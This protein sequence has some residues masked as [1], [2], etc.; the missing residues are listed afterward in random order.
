[1]PENK[2]LLSRGHCWPSEFPF[3][4]REFKPELPRIGSI[5][6]VF[7][8]QVVYF[9]VDKLRKCFHFGRHAVTST[10]HPHF[11]R[12]FE[13]MLLIQRIHQQ[14]NA[15]SFRF[16]YNF[17]SSGPVFHYFP[18]RGLRIIK[19]IVRMNVRDDV[20]SALLYGALL[21]CFKNI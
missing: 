12:A 19:L 14:K 9:N 11:C 5:L 6:S 2:E 21:T 10:A 1:M 16:L 18:Y 13:N 3:W 8:N 17:Y 7:H 15:A 4:G 20:F